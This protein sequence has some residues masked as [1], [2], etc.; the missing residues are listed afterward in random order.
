MNIVNVNF[1]RASSY[2]VFPEEYRNPKNGLIN[3]RNN[4]NECFKWTVARHFCAD[5]RNP[6]R[7]TKKLKEEAEKLNFANIDFPVAVNKIYTFEI[8]NQIFINVYS[9]NNKLELY[10]LRISNG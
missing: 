7:I 6:Q 5:E 2:I 3:I 9:I 1:L 10:P 4:D 8:N